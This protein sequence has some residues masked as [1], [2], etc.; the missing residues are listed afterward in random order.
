MR[1]S[2]ILALL[3]GSE[4]VAYGFS[5][6][7]AAPSSWR[8]S[9]TT[10]TTT[11]NNLTP[12]PALVVGRTKQPV[13]GQNNVLARGGASTT[14]IFSTPYDTGSKCPVTGLATVLASLWGTT[15][16]LYILAKA[17]K[18]VLPIA[19]EP[20]QGNLPALSQFELGYVNYV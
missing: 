17:I 6:R 2:I 7:P 10:T 18:R 4:N 14:R 9:S 5:Q 19:L 13:V 20:F 8:R 11:N 1:C 15:G 12:P 3:A 16:V